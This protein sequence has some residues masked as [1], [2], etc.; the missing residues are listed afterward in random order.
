MAVEICMP[1][2]SQTTDDV[3]FL[4]W[5]V[6]EGEHIKKGDPICEVETD[7]TTMEV[8]SFEGG[9]VL[10]LYT[11]PDEVV[12][13]G[14]VIAALGQPGEPPPE[15]HAAAPPEPSKEPLEM[16]QPEKILKPS[17][18]TSP[19]A[20]A[21]EPQ[22]QP[23]RAVPRAKKTVDLAQT[24]LKQQRGV[25]A[26]DGVLATPLVR[27]IARKKNIDLADVR[28][29]GPRGLITRKDL[30]DY[31]KSGQRKVASGQKRR[32][33]ELSRN[34]QMVARNLVKS[35]SE[36][37][38]FYLKCEVFTDRLSAWREKNRHT[39]GSKVSVYSLLIHAAARALKEFP[40]MYGYFK[41]NKVVLFG[42]IH[43]GFAIAAGEE[44]YVPVIKDADQKTIKEI[45]RE[46]KWLIA[47]AQ[48][49]KLEPQDI[50]GGTF[51]ITNLGI[52]PVDEFCAIINPPQSGIL[53]IGHMKKTLHIDESN[54]MHIRQACT[55]TG[56]FDHRVINGARGAAFLQ[57]YKQIIEDEL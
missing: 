54:A 55:V 10:K 7:K 21:Q 5:L 2:L 48:N 36:A 34:Q 41:D 35:K 27:N 3:R 24:P 53:A 13:A 43:V 4:R 6:K 14:T 33:Y 44:L 30:E 39:D 18:V 56:S 40:H 15:R 8:E 1:R 52:Y 28:G 11:A 38:H 9:T 12:T 26:Q 17:I 29:T 19:D 31:M 20:G 42:G 45:D 37:P 50:M 16:A 23:G 47:K 49:G 57:R 46:V 32:E 25:K 22:G 51:T